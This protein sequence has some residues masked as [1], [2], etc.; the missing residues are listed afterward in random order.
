M[1]TYWPTKNRCFA[2]S[3]QQYYPIGG[4]DN[5]GTKSSFAINASLPAANQL[6]LW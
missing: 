2:N 1:F 6:F 4:A 5:E 3:A